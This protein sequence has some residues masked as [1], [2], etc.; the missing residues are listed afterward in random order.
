MLALAA[1]NDSDPEV[2]CPTLAHGRLGVSRWLFY[3]A[4]REKDH[5]VRN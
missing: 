1:E 4:Q 5:E 2:D 3:K